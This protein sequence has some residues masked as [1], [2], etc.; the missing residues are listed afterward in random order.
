MN[1]EEKNLPVPF[2]DV[3]SF[4]SHYNEKKFW[5]KIINIAKGAGTAILR[6]ALTLYYVL[7]DGNVSVTNKAYIIG[8]LG[9]F[10]LPLDII[11]DFIAGIGYTDDL[12]VIA[13][14]LKQ[15]NDN[16]TPQI[17]EKVDLKIDELFR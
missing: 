14:L 6:P 17:K 12:A 15:V 7:T 16:I 4:E 1:E 11:P 9:Y 2:D 13:I 8:A 5:D 3:P 10:I